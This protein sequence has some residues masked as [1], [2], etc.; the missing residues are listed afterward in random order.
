MALGTLDNS[1]K[2]K[3][4]I[5]ISHGKIVHY[6][7]TNGIEYYKNV[8]GN[9]IDVYKKKRV[10]NGQEFDFWYIDIK[11]GEEIY[12]ISLPYESGTFKSIIL[13]LAS[14]E[15]L[16]SKTRV[17][18]EPYE[19]NQFTKVMVYA[20]GQKLDWITKEIPPLK[21]EVYKGKT[22]TDDSERMEFITNFANLVKE[23][24]TR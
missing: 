2:R 1:S 21:T 17:T 5:S 11:D 6:L 23:R 14:F 15:G 16:T 9:V 19:K 18:I 13:S 10:F 8:T 4:Y 20:D 24:V 12:S 22:I 3:I 7:N